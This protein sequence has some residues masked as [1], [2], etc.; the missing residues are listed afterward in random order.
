MYH[1][2][3]R[4]GQR[5]TSITATLRQLLFP[6]A[7]PHSFSL[8]ISVSPRWTRRAGLLLAARGASSPTRSR[9][10][11]EE[12]YSRAAQPRARFWLRPTLVAIMFC[13]R[14]ASRSAGGYGVW[15]HGSTLLAIYTRRI[16]MT[17]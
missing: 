7:L 3:R 14:M 17:I 9:T 15:A 10:A 16:S 5:S 11:R 4:L 12:E 13:R 6:A 2:S 1:R 8:M